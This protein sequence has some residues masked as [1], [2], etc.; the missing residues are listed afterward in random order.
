MRSVFGWSYPP[1]AANDPS[2]P[3]NQEDGPC[4]VCGLSIDNGCVCKEC[5]LCGSV[6]DPYCYDGGTR[7]V[8]SPKTGKATPRK[9]PGHGMART[10]Q[11]IA[12]RATAEK[13]WAEE[14]AAE[15]LFFEQMEIAERYRAALYGH[16]DGWIGD[17]F[18][19]TEPDLMQAIGWASRSKG[20]KK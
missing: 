8:Y 9:R 3:W 16:C 18:I 11:Q 2:A 15:N 17:E 14:V 5:P 20:T 12:V 13:R 7:Y 6:G 1:G 10:P 19:A 4:D